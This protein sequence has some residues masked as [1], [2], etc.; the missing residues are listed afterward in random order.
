VCSPSRRKSLIS[1]TVRAIQILDIRRRWAED[2]LLVNWTVQTRFVSVCKPRPVNSSGDFH[3][4]LP[5]I[6]SFWA[7]DLD[8]DHKTEVVTIPKNPDALRL[9]HSNAGARVSIGASRKGNSGHAAGQDTKARRGMVGPA[10]M[11]IAF[12][13]FPWL[14]RKAA[15]A[16]GLLSKSDG[17][18]RREN[19]P[20]LTGIGDI[21]VADWDVTARRKSFSLSADEGRSG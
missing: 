2:L 15:Q 4:T 13:I 11:G 9:P 18:R 10:S 12:P 14:S 21:A 16:Y 19:V 7:D 6:R 5:P 1:G 8:G 3:F 20:T 17:T